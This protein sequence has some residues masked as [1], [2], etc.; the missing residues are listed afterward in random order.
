M[1]IFRDLAC[2][3]CLIASDGEIKIADFGMSKDTDVYFVSEGL[4]QIP[5]KWTAPEA[6]NFG[7][8]K[9]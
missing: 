1:Y 5:M 4:K 6:L 8:T 2:R 7:M 3:N 9:E